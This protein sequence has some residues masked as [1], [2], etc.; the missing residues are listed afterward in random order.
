MMGLP[1]PMTDMGSAVPS[2]VFISIVRNRYDAGREKRR[3]F[4]E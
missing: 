1:F 3:F 4:I 2:A